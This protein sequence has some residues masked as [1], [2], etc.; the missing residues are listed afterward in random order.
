ME[1]DIATLIDSLSICNAKLYEVCSLK[2]ACDNLS[3]EELIALCK[4]DVSLCGERSKLKNAINKFFGSNA[5][6]VKTY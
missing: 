3:R 2:K 6:E 5:V 1:I 4:K